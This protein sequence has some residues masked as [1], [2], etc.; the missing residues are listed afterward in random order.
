MADIVITEF[1]AESS[2]AS[3]AAEFDVRYAPELVDDRST[4]LAAVADARAVVVRNR[5]LVDDELLAAAPRLKVVARLGVGLDNIDVAACEEAGVAVRPALGANADAVAEYVVAAVLMLFRGVFSSSSRLVDGEWPREELTG[6][7]IGG[8]RLGLIGFGD[9]A[10]RVAV[11]L[12]GL[13]ME[14]A[15]HDPFLDPEDP[16]WDGTLRLDL[17]ELLATCHA[18]SVH[19]PL[20]PETRH[21]IDAA[22]LES[23]PVGSVLV[24]TSRGGVVDEHALADALRSGH[25]GGAALDVFENE[26]L[27]EAGGRRFVDV[28]NLILTPHVAGIT[29]ESNDRVSSMT[30]AHVRDELAVD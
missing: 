16:A 29:V 19:V 22:A 5:T 12:R 13:G 21:L 24:N 25:L 17:D 1:M 2:V 9:I 27:D 10:R 8:R 4:L 20:T 23:M 30:A 28:P 11:R 14:I 26:P 3:L 6:Q 18:T 15:A 7:E